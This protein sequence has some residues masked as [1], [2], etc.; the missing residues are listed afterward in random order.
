MPAG[1]DLGVGLGVDQHLQPGRQHLP[2]PHALIGAAQA[3]QQP[4]QGRLVVGHRV[5]R[6]YELLGRYSQS[7]T[8]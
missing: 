2:H 5:G 8:R 1:A 4:E 6:L 7:L 3:L